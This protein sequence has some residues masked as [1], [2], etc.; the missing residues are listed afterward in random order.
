MNF[1]EAIISILLSPSLLWAVFGAVLSTMLAF[2]VPIIISSAHYRGR[3]D[4]LGSWKSSYQGIDEPQD[5]WV[6]E[7]I[8]IDTHYGKLRLKNS[9]SSEGYDYTATGEL[10]PGNHIIGQWLS[11]RRGANANG[12]FMLTVSGQGES[13]YG[14]WVGSDKVGARRYGRWVL[15]R[16]EG[17]INE[18]RKHI[19]EMRKSRVP[20]FYARNNV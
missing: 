8:L 11:I 20:K 12:C 17:G 3:T 19:D 13:M 14:Y 1:I 15:A 18:A 10:A 6:N 7:E 5:T 2:V 16:A 9:N 4:L